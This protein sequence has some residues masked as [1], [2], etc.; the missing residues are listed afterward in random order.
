V[1]HR[2]IISHFYELPFGQ[3]RRYANEGVLS[4]IIGNWNLSGIWG[5]ATGGHFTPTLAS[6]VSNSA[7]GSGQRPHLVGN[8]VLPPGERTIERWF[9]TRLDEA[10]APFATPAQY[11]FGNQ[12]RGILDGPGRFNVDLGIHRNFRVG[13]RY[14]VNFRWEMFNAFNRANFADPNA[15]IGG[16]NVG[17]VLNT[18]AARVM[19]FGLKL[20]F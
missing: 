3:G 11:T 8:P 13:E 2:V 17:R 1:R 16:G 9:D 14:N 19:Q 18:G 10:G 4:H 20:E 5:M 6:S 12:G 7:G 15:Q